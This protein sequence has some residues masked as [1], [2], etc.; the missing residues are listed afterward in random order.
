M[1]KEDGHKAQPGME[2]SSDSSRSSDK[3]NEQVE[4]TSS[5]LQQNISDKDREDHNAR[6]QKVKD[7]RANMEKPTI[8][9]KILG[10]TPEI[11]H[12]VGQTKVYLTKN[13]VSAIENKNGET[14]QKTADGRI[15]IDKQDRSS[16]GEIQYFVEGKLSVERMGDKITAVKA[17]LEFENGRQVTYRNGEPTEIKHPG[18]EV[19]KR[20]GK[21][22]NTWH[23]TAHDREHPGKEAHFDIT[24]VQINNQNGDIKWHVLSGEGKGHDRV[25]D[26]HGKYHDY[27]RGVSAIPGERKLAEKEIGR[28]DSNV[29]SAEL[30]PVAEL[31]AQG[32]QP[33]SP[34]SEQDDETRKGT[35]AILLPRKEEPLVELHAGPALKIGDPLPGQNKDAKLETLSKIEQPPKLQVVPESEPQQEGAKEYRVKLNRD[36][37]TPPAQKYVDRGADDLLDPQGNAISLRDQAVQLGNE[38]AANKSDIPI[39]QPHFQKYEMKAPE[40]PHLNKSADLPPTPK[41]TP[42]HKPELQN[43]KPEPAHF[44][45][46][47]D[48]MLGQLPKPE[49]KSVLNDSAEQRQAFHRQALEN[50]QRIQMEQRARFAFQNALADPKCFIKNDFGKPPLRPGD[51]PRTKPMEQQQPFVAPIPINP[52]A[53]NDLQVPQPRFKPQPV[54]FAPPPPI[55]IPTKKNDSQNPVPIEVRPQTR[56]PDQIRKSSDAEPAA[57][58]NQMSEQQLKKSNQ[59]AGPPPRSDHRADEPRQSNVLKRVGAPPSSGEKND[60]QQSG[61]DLPHLKKPVLSAMQPGVMDHSLDQKAAQNPSHAKTTAPELNQT[62]K[63]QYG[64]ADDGTKVLQAR[65]EEKGERSGYSAGIPSTDSSNAYKASADYQS[66]YSKPMEG[67]LSDGRKIISANARSNESSDQIVWTQWHAKMEHDLGNQLKSR[68]PIGAQFQVQFQIDRNGN[69]DGQIVKHNGL[70]QQQ[71]NR[72]NEVLHYQMRAPQGGGDHSLSWTFKSIGHGQHE[73]QIT[74]SATEKHSYRDGQAYASQF[75]YG[76]A[77]N[78]SRNIG[79]ANSYRP[80]QQPQQVMTYGAYRR[81]DH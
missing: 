50:L 4:K 59:L 13:Q 22:K 51:L 46:K 2:R 56:T 81:S 24:N 55:E 45:K 6:E 65:V 9:G 57:S 58:I 42:Q 26:G 63:A 43:P 73:S 23:V 53:G 78:V 20:D 10:G 49:L 72:V 61:S 33:K 62:A 16:G 44:E 80:V 32:G 76:A 67:R 18:G 60:G 8:S 19:W 5:S 15:Q 68:V 37:L 77:T 71:I 27:D 66:A 31:P 12:D 11:G 39:P 21:D 1:A 25:I 79:R 70:T 30:K 34:A 74:H 36:S 7:I 64:I 38:K 3:A 40:P 75:S 28:K 29:Q 17:E 48:A 54:P 47:A 14:W 52:L 69:A 41:P 35:E